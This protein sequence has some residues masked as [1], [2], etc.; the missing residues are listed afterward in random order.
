MSR[1]RAAD[2]RF[3]TRVVHA[4]L[5]PDPSLRL[6]HPG[7]PPDLDLRAAGGRRV[8]RGLRL[9]ALGEPDAR[10]RSRRRSASSRAATASRSPPGMAADPR[11]DHRGLRGGR[12]HRAAERP[13]R[14]HLPARRQ[15]ARR[16]GLNYDLVDQTD[17]DA[18]GRRGARR[19]A[20]D[21][22]RDADEPAAER[23]RHRGRRRPA[24]AARSSPSTTRSPRRSTSARWSSAPTPSCTRR[25][26]T[27]A[28]TPTSS[29]A[30]SIARD[31]D[32]H[33][34]VR[35][36]QNSVGAVPGPVRLLPRPPRAA[37]AAPADARA[38]RAARGGRRAPA[39]GPT[40][41]RTSAGPG[42]SGMVSFRHAD[43]IG[44]RA[45]HAALHARRVARRRRVAD[46][47]A[48]RR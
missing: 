19:D 35:F 33:E 27:S 25:R 44:D 30:R 47:G 43:A 28:A 37:H 7:D 40:A 3:A 21:L 18:L 5:E 8:R 42:F 9:R 39:R 23:R 13:L 6:G 48:R 36:V 10:A 34:H 16:W 46:R 1:R 31:P 45:A 17:L 12:P 11:A 32:R 20:A 24:R 29:A 41:S 22:G 38:R 2:A 14:R 15:G 4:G 26:S